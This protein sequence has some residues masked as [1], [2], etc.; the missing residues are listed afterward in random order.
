VALRHAGLDGLEAA[1]H[2]LGDGDLRLGELVAGAGEGGGD[3]LQVD[4]QD[5]VAQ[6]E[7]LLELEEEV[8]CGEREFG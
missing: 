6:T 3:L 8:Q 1:P 2:Q 5:L 7:R 4:G